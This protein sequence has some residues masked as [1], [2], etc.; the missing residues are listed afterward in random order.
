MEKSV[1][2]GLRR[3][4][5]KKSYTDHW[6]HCPQTPQPE[7]VRWGLGAET[8]A[9]EVSSR[10]RTRVGCLEIV[11]KGYGAVHLG[12]GR[13]GAESHSQGNV[14]G[15][16]VP[17]EEQGAI[18]GVGKRRRGQTA[19]G[20]LFSVHIQALGHWGASCVGY[21]WQGQ[22]ATTIS[23]SRGERGHHH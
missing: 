2:A 15:G 10:E 4:K 5:Q 23:D 8:Q 22:T 20:I 19:I 18:F 17:Q 12:L 6:Y 3:S 21:V 9:S 7:T 16:L 11:L 13:W 14:G 1:A